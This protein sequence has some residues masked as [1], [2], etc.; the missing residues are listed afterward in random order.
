MVITGWNDA[1]DAFPSLLYPPDVDAPNKGVWFES[2]LPPL[3]HIRK[4]L[5]STLQILVHIGGV[6]ILGG[7]HEA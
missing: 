4:Q 5:R 6:E 1:V 3:P 2:L 7:S